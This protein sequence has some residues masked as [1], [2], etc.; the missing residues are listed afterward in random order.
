MALRPPGSRS[1]I[2]LLISS[3]WTIVSLLLLIGGHLVLALLLYVKFIQQS[4]GMEHIAK[5]TGLEPVYLWA[6]IGIALAL[7][8]WIAVSSKREREKKIRR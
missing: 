1:N 8:V 3:L 4:G 2:T 5:F 6:S 7:D